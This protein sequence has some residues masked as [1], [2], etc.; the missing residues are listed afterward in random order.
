MWLSPVNLR[1]LNSKDTLNQDL[2]GLLRICQ[3]ITNVMEN[4]ARWRNF[5]TAC[6]I[7]IYLHI[8]ARWQDSCIFLLGLGRR[9]GMDNLANKK[10]LVDRRKHKRLQAQ[11]GAFVLL[12]PNSAILG[13]IVEISMGG[14]AFLYI[15][16]EKPP[17]GSSELEILLPEQLEDDHSFYF[18]Q[19][20]FKTISDFAIPN[21]LS[22][23]STTIRRRGV[24]FGE[25][26]HNQT[27][28]LEYFI[29][30]HTIGEV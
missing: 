6:N 9:F 22:L 17:N 19:V 25:L 5:E 10:E 4:M 13:H 27:S 15:T 20:P 23:G 3:E 8:P 12:S 21:E 18:D 1:Q 16:C 29:R 11:E 7:G 14:L 26:T 30:N 28:A 2:E 24:Q